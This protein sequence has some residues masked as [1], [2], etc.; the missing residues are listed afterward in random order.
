LAAGYIRFG[1]K[2]GPHLQGS[3]IKQF[4]M[5]S[6]TIETSVTNHQP[7]PLTS[8]KNG[9]L[10]YTVEEDWKRVICKQT[11]WSNKFKKKK[12]F[13]QTRHYA[14]AVKLPRHIR[15]ITHKFVI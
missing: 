2:N 3:I 15:F 13:P 10:K 11:N 1:T 6:L 9:G 4:F 12:L 7:T 14:P 8:R 5:D